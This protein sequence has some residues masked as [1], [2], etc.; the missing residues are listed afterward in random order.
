MSINFRFH[1]WLIHLHDNAPID[2]ALVQ[3]LEDPVNALQP[4]PTKV[5]TNFS[6]ARE[7]Q[8]FLQVL[9]R[10]DDGATNCDP[11]HH[12]IDDRQ[13]EISRR[14]GDQDN[15]PAAADHMDSLSE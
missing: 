10:T 1:C 11:F 14:Q 2:G 12:G 7:L 13:W 6:F 3:T 15:S 4:L 8:R 9:P 5:R